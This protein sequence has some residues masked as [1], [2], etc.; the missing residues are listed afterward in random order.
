MYNDGLP[1]YRIIEEGPNYKI[2]ELN[3]DGKKQYSYYLYD[4]NNNEA[5]RGFSFYEPPEIEYYNDHVIQIFEEPT[6]DRRFYMF[7]DTIE[8]IVGESIE[9]PALIQDGLAVYM[10]NH[11]V[12]KLVVQDI[13]D[14]NKFYKEFDC[15]FTPQSNPDKS[16]LEAI[17]IQEKIRSLN[18]VYL[19]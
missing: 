17:L 2:V 7:Y 5:Y 8:N 4:S 13:V 1:D 16:L 11:E 15:G 6:E 12:V 14:K 10:V 9:S 3:D 18:A 19:L